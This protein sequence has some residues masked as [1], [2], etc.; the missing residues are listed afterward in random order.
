MSAQGA[1]EKIGVNK[2]D[3]KGK[4]KVNYGGNTKKITNFKKKF[5]NDRACY[6]C[7]KKGHIA[8]NR[9]YHKDRDDGKPNKKVNTT[10][11]DGDEPSGSRLVIFHSYFWCFYLHIG[12]LILR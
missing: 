10:I 3:Y 1:S 9:C 8:K 12:G 7:G 5:E 11:G 6:M 2:P 4:A